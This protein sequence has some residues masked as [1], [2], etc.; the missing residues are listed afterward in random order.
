MSTKKRK[1][2]IVATLLAIALFVY[3]FITLRGVGGYLHK[4]SG[5]DAACLDGS[6]PAYYISY[7]PNK[8]D[9][10]MIIL[11]GGGW[12]FSPEECLYRSTTDLGSSD[13]YDERLDF[14]YGI[15]SRDCSINPIYCMHNMVAIMYCDGSSF[16]GSRNSPLWVDDTPIYFRG[17]RNLE[18]VIT[19][20]IETK[21]LSNASS[22]TTIGESAGGL[23]A[24]VHGDQIG[25]M[26]GIEDYSI[27]SSSGFFLNVPN[28]NG[29]MIFEDGFRRMDEI[30]NSSSTVDQG[31]EEEDPFLCLMPKTAHSLLSSPVFISNSVADSWEINCI[32]LEV[33]DVAMCDAYR[34]VF[35]DEEMVFIEQYKVGFMSNLN[36]SAA[37]ITST[38][39]HQLSFDDNLF[40][41]LI[42][43]YGNT[44]N[45]MLT[46]WIKKL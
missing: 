39:T 22:V 27:I 10:W 26:I 45:N 20:L 44:Q 4:V 42:D 23:A 34:S 17:F 36:S 38:F 14:Q 19:D 35:T 5:T 3:L 2:I 12:C 30:S 15:A 28:I 43:N 9:D 46:N 13:G 8:L 37:F 29:E 24:L 31:C 1:L 33:A 11:R 41:N 7:S 6:D 32:L 21:G 16:S 25:D 18:V 40:K